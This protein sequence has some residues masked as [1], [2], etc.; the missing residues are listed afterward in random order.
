MGLITDFMGSFKT[1]RPL[2]DDELKEYNEE[3]VNNEDMYLIFTSNNKLEGIEESKL[4]GYI[5]ME[6]G[7]SKTL[8]WFKAKKI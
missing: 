6:L 8:N 1:S 4:V 2:T 7:M 5:D 3:Q